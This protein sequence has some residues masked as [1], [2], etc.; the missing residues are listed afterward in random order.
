MKLKLFVALFFLITNQLFAQNNSNTNGWSAEYSKS[1]SFIENLGQF[2]QESNELTGK[3]LYAVDFGSTRIFFGE[4]GICYSFLEAT[5]IPKEERD[6]LRQKMDSDLSERRKY[7]RLIGK[8]LYKSDQVNMTWGSPSKKRS[9]VG[10]EAT[11]DYHNYSFQNKEGNIVSVSNARGYE[12]IVYKNIYPNIDIEYVVHPEIGIKYAI[13]LHPGADPSLVSMNFDRDISLLEGRLDIPTYFGSIIDHAPITFYEGD[14]DAIISSKFVQEQRKI[15]FE[16]G[17]YNKSKTIIID[18]WTQTPAF[19]TNWDVVWECERDGAG[20][21]YILGGIMPMQILKY[22]STGTLQWTYN[23]PYDT[24]NVWLGTFAVDNV[25]NTYVTAGSSAKIQKISTAGALIWDN[26]NPG[27]L[28]ALTEFWNITFNCDQTKL[29]IAGTDGNAFGGP[30]PYIFDVNM[31]NGDVTNAVQVHESVLFNDQE[32]RAITPTKNAKYY[33]LTQDTIGYIYQNFNFCPTNPNAF[34]TTNGMNLGYKCENYRVDNSGIMAIAHYNGFIFVHRGNQLQKRDFATGAILATAAIPGGSYTTSGFGNS[35]GCSGIEIDNCGNIYVGSVNSVVKFDQNLT[36]TGSYPTTYNVYDVEIN[37]N[38]EIIACGGTGNSNSTTRSGGVHSLNATACVPQTITCCDATVCIPQDLCVTDAPVT[39]TPATSGGTWAGPGVNASGVFNP[40][41]AGAGVHNITY[42]LSCGSETIQIVVSTCAS[43]TVCEETNG[44]ITV[45]GG[46]GPYTWAEWIPAQSTPITT[47]AQCTSCGYTWFFGTCLNGALPVTTCNSPAYWSNFGAGTSV[48]PPAS[49]TQIQVTDASG[50]I[51]TFDPATIP[52]CVSN[53]CPTINMTV[54]SQTNVLCFGN[55]TGAATVSASGG[56]G[57]YTYTWTPGNLNGPNQSTLGAGTYSVSIVDGN[58]CPGSGTVTITQ[59]ASALAVTMSSTPTNCGASSGSATASVSGG[60]T[61][62]SYAWTP[63]VG[64]TSTINNL[65]AGTY[66]VV[67]TDANGCQASGNTTVTTNGGPT[68]NVVS[69]TNVSCNGDNDGAAS[70]SG[71]GS[72]TLTY[73][74]APGS[75]SGSTQNALSA[76]TYTVTVTDGGGCTN[77]TTLTITEP[78]AIAITPGTIS[79]ANCGVND[80]SASVNVSG[81]AGGFTYLWTPSGSTSATA[82]NLGGGTY[83]VDVEDQNGCTASTSLVVTNIG[84]P[85]VTLASSSNVSCFGENDGSASVSVTGGS[86]PYTYNW[87]PS[88]GTGATA[89]NLT[90]GTYTVSVTDNT[91][92]VG[93][94]QVIITEPSAISITETITNANCGS[95]DGSITTMI[96]GGAGTYTYLWTPNGETTSGLSALNPGNYGLTV[97]DQDGCQT[98]E[99]YTVSTS[100]SLTINA[101]PVSTS[102]QEGET[103]QL[104]A[105]GA[106]DYTWSPTSGLSCSDCPD[107]LATPSETTIYTV[108]GTDASGCTGS[109]TVTIIVQQVCG[110]IFVPTIFSPNGNGPSAN[111][112]LCIFGGCIAELNYAVFNRWGEKVFETTDINLT[113]C[114]DGTYKDKLLNSGVYAYKLIVTLTNGEYIEES[115]NVTLVR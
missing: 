30:K 4:N 79:P 97:T 73:S 14:Q 59:P 37:S 62:Y 83:T 6:A 90:A 102:I 13:I 19:A 68:I 35:V 45:S 75:L 94:L 57:T 104:N 71:T 40:A 33:Y 7:E 111:N 93:S 65:S 95:S 110:D 78:T 8:F 22:N 17:E 80:G 34:H 91:S 2:D 66:S 64:T 28:L 29:V 100:G 24:S 107:P 92:C 21:V 56:N 85:T 11:S 48:T 23:T 63:N 60:T 112:T 18:P 76:G 58:N 26:P 86:S 108:T 103:V 15:S 31:S 10:E 115:G 54:S 61:N 3:I 12:K 1:K 106:T 5:K 67:V 38:G 109:A 53:P 87:L 32:V 105:T 88:G 96:T 41:T 77:S 81:G 44:N 72:G 70:V 114:W 98:T 39:L 43:L 9:L 89:S 50:S 20:N 25:G 36:Q 51:L 84:G 49:A 69:S 74:W 99:N 101:T 42:T 113:E 82:S 52:A 27:G 47:Q 46:V 16:L 55:T